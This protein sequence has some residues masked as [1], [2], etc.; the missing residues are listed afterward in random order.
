V[1]VAPSKS[2][3][4]EHRIDMEGLRASVR[5]ARET[6]HRRE[7]LTQVDGVMSMTVR[8]GIA[9]GCCTFDDARTRGKQGGIIDELFIHG[10][11]MI[12]NV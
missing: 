2:I 4:R 7:S 6:L 11:L 3:R 5:G 9:F 12:F 10:E 1:S 8:I